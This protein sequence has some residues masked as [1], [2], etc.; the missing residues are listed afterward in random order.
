MGIEWNISILVIKTV[1]NQ[2]PINRCKGNK[3]ECLKN[4]N[5]PVSEIISSVLFPKLFQ[6]KIHRSFK[7]LNY[8][9]CFFS[10]N[11]I[12]A[13]FDVIAEYSCPW[14]WW[15]LQCT[16]TRDGC[17]CSAL[18]AVSDNCA[19]GG[20]VGGGSS[21]LGETKVCRGWELVSD[22]AQLLP[23]PPPR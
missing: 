4:G 21:R 13:M 14:L 6:I 2:H 17:V 5:Y 10:L 19:G 18:A 8:W 9:L 1:T 15:W 11:I 16:V 7:T 22:L 23:P 20:R 3:K 12:W